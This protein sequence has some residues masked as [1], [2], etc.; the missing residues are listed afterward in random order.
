M[1]TCQRWDSFEK[2]PRESEG[3]VEHS[4]EGVV[5]GGRLNGVRRGRRAHGPGG[6]VVHESP[7]DVWICAVERQLET[8]RDIHRGHTLA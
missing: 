7:E 6:Q 5:S 3:Q 4:W 2:T 8:E 1:V